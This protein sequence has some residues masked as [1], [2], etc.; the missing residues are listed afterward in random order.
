MT[1]Q[2]LRAESAITGMETHWLPKL[3]PVVSTMEAK[4]YP[5]AAHAREI[6][7]NL[8]DHVRRALYDLS[9]RD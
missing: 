3:D 5:E 4:E 8:L 1:N 7:R 6:Y 9:T 2:E